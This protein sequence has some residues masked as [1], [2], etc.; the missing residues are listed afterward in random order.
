MLERSERILRIVCLVL[1]ALMVFQLARILAHRN[2]V[3]NLRIPELPTL[4]SSEA[5]ASS[6]NGPAIKGGE[7]ARPSTN[8]LK[9]ASAGNT[10]AVAG[11][12]SAQNSTNLAPA[13]VSTAAGA[14]NVESRV[15]AE[16]AKHPAKGSTNS[17][18]AKPGAPSGTNVAAHASVGPGTNAV[19]R[20][21][22][23]PPPGVT[24]EM[25]R[26]PGGPGGP[27]GPPGKQRDVPPEILARV[28][29]VVDSEILGPIM[30]PL[31]M[32]LLGIAGNTAFLRASSGQ[33][34]LVK[35]GDDLG[36]LKLL[37]IGINRVLVE[38]SGQKKELTI[39]SGLGGESL[40]PN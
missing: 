12:P 32:A 14:T 37:R 30:R 39:F 21:S 33:T 6:T 38:E 31:P 40:L 34:G 5:D 28:D 13:Q 17:V 36:G 25:A 4:A 1:G 11:A 20:S 22:N 3:A 27:P 18:A 8:T 23:S 16:I 29:R 19:A 9:T 10:N 7:A 15:P 35:E 26:G 2:P 24:A